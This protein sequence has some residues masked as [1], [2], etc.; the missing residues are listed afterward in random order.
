LDQGTDR[1]PL[2]ILQESFLLGVLPTQAAQLPNKPASVRVKS[3]S[4]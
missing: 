3:A 4:V 1:T 2:P